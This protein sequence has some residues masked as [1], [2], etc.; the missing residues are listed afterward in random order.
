MNILQ[1]LEQLNPQKINVAEEINYYLREKEYDLRHSTFNLSSLEAH[2]NQL[3]ALK[4]IISI[5]D[6]IVSYLKANQ[7]NMNE[8]LWENVDDEI[9]DYV[10]NLRNLMI[11]YQRE[12]GKKNEWICEAA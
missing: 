11:R 6:N 12:F 1:A 7:S 2:K 9:Y 5:S 8:F 3:Q 10:F 4:N